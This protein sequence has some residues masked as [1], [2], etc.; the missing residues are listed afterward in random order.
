MA[1]IASGL[2][3]DPKLLGFSLRPCNALGVKRPQLC[4]LPANQ[5]NVT[6]I[7]L[8]GLYSGWRK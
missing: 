6:S 1:Y 4:L 5:K 8:V 3:R 7:A 2:P